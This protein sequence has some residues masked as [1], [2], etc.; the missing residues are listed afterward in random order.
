MVIFRGVKITEEKIAMLEQQ[1]PTN[2]VDI[3]NFK[4]IWERRNVGRKLK[5]NGESDFIVLVKNTCVISIEVKIN[6]DKRKARRQHSRTE[7]FCNLVS[8][9]IDPSF[10]LPLIKVIFMFV[11]PT[12]IN[13]KTMNDK[14]FGPK[15]S[16]MS[17]H[18]RYDQ[19]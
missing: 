17:K 12:I 4:T 5:E 2:V 3:A 10:S 7:D 18:T 6:K 15:K 8:K 13:Q 16:H 19:K 9:I 14:V 1:F 11:F